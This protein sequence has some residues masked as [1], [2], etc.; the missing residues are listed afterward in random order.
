MSDAQVKYAIILV[1]GFGTR[2]QPL[3]LERPKQ[4]LPICHKPMIEIVVEKLK[5]AGITNVVLALGY[6]PDAFLEAYP[7]GKCQGVSLEYA[8]E[9]EPLD[10]AGAI[11]FAF[12]SANLKEETFLA[13]N[14][15][16]L[17]DADLSQLI[18]THFEKSG[19]ATILSVQ[20][21]DPSRYGVM[22]IGENS[23]VMDFYEK[24][25]ADQDYGNNI[26][27]GIYA[28][29]ASFLRH[30]QSGQRVSLEKEIF[31]ELIQ[32]GKLFCHSFNTYWLDTGTPE[33]YLKAQIDFAD[34][35]G[36]APIATSAEISDSAQ[37]VESVIGEKV[38]IMSGAKVSH[39][40]ILE[41]AVLESGAVVENSI[42]GYG[43]HIG[44][45]ASLR[46]LCVIGD[47][48]K[49]PAKAELAGA[50]ISS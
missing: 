13:V 33:T 17:T 4:M 19:E 32:E 48:Q 28:M 18:A 9:P 45:G 12:E 22:K 40:V 6:K 10:T 35:T 39:S 3:T 30:I 8:I 36:Q 27:A 37:V 20:V 34:K 1:G 24:P 31:P 15:D 38:S 44:E 50:K 23:E 42:L 5:K 16:V 2:L 43:V 7:D 47:N 25:S 46:N 26:N 14:G 11:K 21:K 49:I 29:N 41:G